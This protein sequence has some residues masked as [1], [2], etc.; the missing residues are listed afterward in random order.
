MTVLGS[1][2]D[3]NYLQLKDVKLT[4][5]D[6]YTTAPQL[7]KNISVKSGSGKEYENIKNVALVDKMLALPTRCATFR[8]NHE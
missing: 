8:D 6:G 5:G 2:V 1:K 3:G 4:G 7:I